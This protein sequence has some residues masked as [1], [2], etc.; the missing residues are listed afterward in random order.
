ML[1]T[2]G[3]ILSLGDFNLPGYDWLTHSP[4]TI[5]AASLEQ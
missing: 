4:G 5:E 1:V 2:K 3:N